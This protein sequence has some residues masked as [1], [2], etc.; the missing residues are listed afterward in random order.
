MN[1]AAANH[2]NSQEITTELDMDSLHVLPL[3]IM[4]LYT[5]GLKQAA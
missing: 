3:R 4:P 5:T 1:T 2:I